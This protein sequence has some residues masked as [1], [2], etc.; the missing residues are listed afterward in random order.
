MSFP[1][2]TL[3]T[4]W[5]S[6]PLFSTITRPKPVRVPRQPWVHRLRLKGYDPKDV[7]VKVDGE[8][9][10]VHAKHEVVKGDNMDRY[11][12][13]RSVVVPENVNKEKLSSYLLDDEHLVITAPFED[14]KQ[15]SNDKGY[16]EIEIKHE[17]NGAEGKKST[18]EEN[19]LVT[20]KSNNKTEGDDEAFIVHE[21]GLKCD[22]AE[23]IQKDNAMKLADEETIEKNAVDMQTTEVSEMD[24]LTE[25][26]TRRETEKNTGDQ[27]QEDTGSIEDTYLITSAPPSRSQ[28]VDYHP[29]DCSE[30]L[31]EET[32]ELEDKLDS[33]TYIAPLMDSTQTIEIDEEP[34]H[35]IMMNLKN[36]K[37]ENVSVRIKNNLL[38]VDAEKEW[39]NDGIVTKQKVKR[40]FVVPENSNTENVAVKM[41]DDGIVKIL[42]PLKPV[43]CVELKKAED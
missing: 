33:M 16:M 24:N 6:H 25:P 21:L 32:V 42:V 19:M 15:T 2:P 34:F 11:E 29:L 36:F 30:K 26:T 38:L 17:S 10:I 7:S 20:P 28:S 31:D 13:R 14:V 43:D 1:E 39:N 35:Q 37:P 5:R 22:G 18:N 41:N 4:V 23:S 27:E 40:Q 8:K 9:V 3:K 12:I